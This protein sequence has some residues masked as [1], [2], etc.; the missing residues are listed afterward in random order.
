MMARGSANWRTNGFYLAVG[1][2]GVQR[3]VWE[4]LKPDEAWWLPGSPCSNYCRLRW[5]LT[6]RSG[7]WVGN[8]LSQ[9]DIWLAIFSRP[10][11]V[12]RRVRIV[13]RRRRRRRSHFPCHAAIGRLRKIFSGSSPSPRQ[14][15][16]LPRHLR[17]G[18]SNAES[19]GFSV[20]ARIAGWVALIGTVLASLNMAYSN[21]FAHRRIRRRFPEFR[22]LVR[23][24]FPHWRLAG[25]P[26]QTP[27]N[28][29]K[30]NHAPGC[31]SAARHPRRDPA[32]TRRCR[33]R[34]C[35]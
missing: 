14:N 8:G 15:V 35:S 34:S 30:L 29:R 26:D 9:R 24:R 32:A 5:S 23:H 3:F 10:A 33:S 13:C 12:A 16:R 2:Y 11:A 6:R 25:P 18:Q 20:A 22:R 1:F 19:R 31:Q 7:S 17:A 27:Q 28:S 4:F 21:Y